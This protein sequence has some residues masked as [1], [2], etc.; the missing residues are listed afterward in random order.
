MQRDDV[1]DHVNGKWK[2]ILGTFGIPE[3]ALT[4]KHGPCPLCGGTDRFRWDNK[5]GRGTYICSHC[6]S[7]DGWD[8]LMKFKGWDFK[9]AARE[10]RQV[11][12]MVE[13]HAPRQ[14]QT[15]EQH[16]EAVRRLW[17]D[18][19]AVQ[20]GDP[21]DRYLSARGVGEM[22]YPKSL[23]TCERCWFARGQEYPAMVAAVCGPDGK[24]VT[25]HRTYLDGQGGKAPVTE[26]K[27]LMPG[28]IPHGS[29]IRLGE[30]GEVLGI[31]E[32]IETAL[33]AMQRFEVPVWA[34][35]SAG[36]MGHWEPPEGVEE[37]LVC[38]DNDTSFAGQAAAYQLAHRLSLKGLKVSVQLPEGAGTDWA[39]YAERTA[40]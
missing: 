17:N 30:P 13:R 32:G 8:L 2:G 9:T 6:G 20:K 35:I 22:A 15:P 39:D 3:S 26:P 23:R 33:A 25:L 21:V 5:D 29:A 24:G 40:A 12:G 37:V 18:C 36:I 34:A 7:G 10:V 11:V 31:A 27:K 16:R 19:T 28:K 4:G 38:G 14:E 1:R